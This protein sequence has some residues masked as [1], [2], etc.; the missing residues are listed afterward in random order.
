MLVKRGV[1]VCTFW[2]PS[3]PVAFLVFTARST[4]LTLCS[5]TLNGVLRAGS[6]CCS[7]FSKRAKKQSSFS[8]HDTL[9]LHCLCSLWCILCHTS[10]K[11][12][13]DMWDSMLLLCPPSAFWY[14][15][16][17]QL[18]QPIE[19]CLQ[20]WRHHNGIWGFCQQSHF[21]CRTLYSAIQW[22]CPGPDVQYNN[23]FSLMTNCSSFPKSAIIIS[24]KTWCWTTHFKTS[25]M[26]PDS[27]LVKI[28]ILLGHHLSRHPS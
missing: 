27:E 22:M 17:G 23:Y 24:I 7:D 28:L 8:A 16:F 1:V 12:L 2:A 20:I 5:C 10:Q 21:Q 9:M 6:E 13:L 14:L 3:G 18:K 4:C 11:L 15:F 26:A 25:I 19:F